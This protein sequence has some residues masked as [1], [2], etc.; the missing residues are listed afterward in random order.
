ME[1]SLSHF[2]KILV[3]ECRVFIHRTQTIENAES[4]L[5]EGLIY[6]QNF[7]KV[8]QE[9]GNDVERD[10]E[11]NDLFLRNYGSN[12]III[13]IPKSFKGHIH[14]LTETVSEEEVERLISHVDIEDVEFEEIFKLPNQYIKALYTNKQF[15]VN[16]E[17]LEPA[18]Q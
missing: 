10:L 2:I 12:I 8:T 11:A 14:E 15:K 5:K 4:I 9:I 18:Y 7:H 1:K 16:E 13:A 17:I 6:V 3:K